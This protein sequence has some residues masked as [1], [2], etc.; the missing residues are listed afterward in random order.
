MPRAADLPP[1]FA[2]LPPD[3]MPASPAL[4]VAERPLAVD[5]T[6]GRAA[7]LAAS[8]RLPAVS[9]P[10]LLATVPGSENCPPG[11]PSWCEVASPDFGADLPPRSAAVLAFA[12]N[13][14]HAIAATI[15]RL[16]FAW[17][18]II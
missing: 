11:E 5:V 8:L 3:S 15:H 9:A 16:V 7:R 1:V 14:A 12:A 10:A 2:D 4:P 17:R 6:V 18:F 13:T